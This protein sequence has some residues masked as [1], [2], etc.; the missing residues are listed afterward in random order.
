MNVIDEYSKIY[1]NCLFLED[2]QA[3]VSEKSLAE[4]NGVKWGY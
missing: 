4:L 1:Q 3:S 2:F